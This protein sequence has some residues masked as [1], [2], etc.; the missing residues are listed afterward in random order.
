[1][2][3]INKLIQSKRSLLSF[4]IILLVIA[5]DQV[6]KFLIRS[7]FYLGQSLPENSFFSIT[8]VQNTGAV[9]GVFQGNNRILMLVVIIEAFLILFCYAVARLRYH[10]WDTTFISVVFGLIMGGLIGNL[11]D[12]INLGFVTDFISV[13]PWPVFNIADS[14]GVVGVILLIINIL[15]MKR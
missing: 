15:F 7:N 12:R 4:V 2:S 9:F 6:S 5:A 13:G 1:M 3:L 8:Y 11:I 10:E 14:A